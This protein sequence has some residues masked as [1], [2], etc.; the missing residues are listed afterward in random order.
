MKKN[1]LIKSVLFSTVLIFTLS[2][3]SKDFLIEPPRKVTI[4]DLLD[5]PAD[6]AQRLTGAVYSKL[7]DW[8]QHSF[9]WIGVSS[10]ASDDADKGSD[11]GDSGADKHE[12]DGWTFT[13]SGLSFKEL[14]ESNY[15]GIG[16]SCYAIEYIT[17]MELEGKERYIAESKFLRAY[18]YFNLVR[19]F[20]GVPLVNQV[21]DNLEE[22]EAA[23]VRASESE[24]YQQIISDLT[25]AAAG[26]PNTVSASEAG[27]VS[28]D[29]ANALLAKVYLY[30]KD[31]GSAIAYCD[32]IIGSSRYDLHDDYAE[33]FRESGEFCEESIWEVNAIGT[34]P[35]K[36]INGYFVVQAPRTDLGWGFNTPSQNLVDAYEAGDVR[37]A[38]TIMERGQTLWDGHLVPATCP[39]LYYNYKCYVSKTHE[40]FSGNDSETNKNLRIL[41]YADILLIKA[42]SE[43]ELGDTTTAKTFVNMIR[44]RAGL[45]PVDNVGSVDNLREII[46]NERRLEFAM[47]HERT[48]DLRRTGKDQEVYSALGLPFTTGKHELFPIPQSQIDL[49]G[50]TL[51]QNP[52]Y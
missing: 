50:G 13:T 43:N 30:M 29:A 48:F 5:N 18:F 15:E 31:W 19:M 37:K 36:G 6:G 44:E 47:E 22:V 9:S 27:R 38:G 41:R 4:Q 49:S 52:G 45:D 11:P 2:T 32:Q 21:L 1:Q 12:L 34:T 39:N 8:N 33:I 3:C 46:Y 35:E 7:Y 40:S 16:R 25:A 10:I 24:I 14:W 20:G 23:S 28:A 26:L 51:I 17:Q 42:E